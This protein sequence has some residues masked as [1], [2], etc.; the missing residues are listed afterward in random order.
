MPDSQALVKTRFVRYHSESTEEGVHLAFPMMVVHED[1]G[2]HLSGWVF[3]KDERNTAGLSDGANWKPMVGR[4]G[5]G[6]PGSWSDFDEE[7]A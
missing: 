4:G 1:E 6:V 2:E 3:A 5:P 7:G